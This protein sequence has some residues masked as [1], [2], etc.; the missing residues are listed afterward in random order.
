MN[1]WLKKIL[2]AFLPGTCILCESP[3]H[4]ALDLCARCESELP[5][6]HNQC[7]LCGIPLPIGNT[8][9]GK[10]LLYKPPF[11]RC[12]S[13]FI[14]EYPIDRL[15][16]EF[17]ENHRLVIGKILAKLLVESFPEEFTP[18]DLLIPVPLHKSSLRRRGF[19]QSIEI[20][21]VLS[22]TWSIPIDSRNCRRILRTAE[23]KSLH[24]QDRI[25]N[26]R[27][28]FTIDRPY[29]GQRIAIVDDVVTTGATVSEL[30]RLIMSEGAGAIEV[31]CLAR[32]PA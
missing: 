21:E 23:Q 8:I 3:S 1:P 29:N 32:T 11:N 4:R 18:P 5:W 13:A 17:K 2:Y 31:I 24:T 6:L 30:A 25:R 9:C 22:D 28:A 7:T 20:A 27:G 10:C 19:N 15:I 14:Y 16:L 12:Y 26:V